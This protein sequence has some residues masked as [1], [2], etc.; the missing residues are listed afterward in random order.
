[1]KLDAGERELLAEAEKPIAVDNLWMLDVHAAA[2][3]LRLVHEGLMGTTKI[4][5]RVFVY[6]TEA[7]RAKG[8]G[9]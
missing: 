7:G 4:R 8:A 2:S 1:M 5:G 3:A 9:R 6:T